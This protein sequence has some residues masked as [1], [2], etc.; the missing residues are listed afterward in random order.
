MVA[1]P[2]RFVTLTL[3]AEEW[4]GEPDQHV[5]DDPELDHGPVYDAR[6][7]PDGTVITLYELRGDPDQ[8]ESLLRTHEDRDVASAPTHDGSGLLVYAHG[9]AHETVAALLERIQALRLVID[10]PIEFRPDGSLRVTLVGDERGVKGLFDGIP[11]SVSLE[12]ERTGDYEPRPNRIYASLTDR[13]R[14]ILRTAVDLGYYRRPRETSYSEIAAV[15]G[16]SEANVGEH[17]RRIESKLVEAI[18]P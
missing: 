12:I 1:D 8:L 4:L 5:F 16:C 10:R 18:V 11:E 6:L 9:E 3:T 14:E 7:L 15:V 2:L 17:I 13:Q